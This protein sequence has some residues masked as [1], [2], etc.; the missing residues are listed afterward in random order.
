MNDACFA[1]TYHVIPYCGRPEDG[2]G[3]YYLSSTEDYVKG[4][5]NPMPNSSVRGRNI[6]M[7][8]LYTS[9][10]RANW[11]LKNEITVVG[12]LVTNRIG[13]PDDHKNAKQ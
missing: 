2:T 1:F 6:S 13:L 4:L 3:L 8:R 7:D 5:V 9:I 10:S 12:T 11:L